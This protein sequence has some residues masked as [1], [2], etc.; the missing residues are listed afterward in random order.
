MQ[1]EAS[2]SGNP[3]LLREF[4]IKAKQVKAAV[5]IDKKKNWEGNLGENVSVIQAWNNAR[6]LLGSSK[7]L[8]PT[9]IN[10]NGNLSTSPI[11]IANKK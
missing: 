6:D 7:N 8:S 5:K 3:T 10:Q 1:E 11:Q 2:A 4:K 9:T